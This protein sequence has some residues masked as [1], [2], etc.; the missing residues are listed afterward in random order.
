MNE[1]TKELMN[2]SYYQ[3]SSKGKFKIMI[4][5]IKLKANWEFGPDN[6]SVVIINDE[7]KDVWEISKI[8]D[9]ELILLKGTSEEKWIWATE[10]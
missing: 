5:F 8:S 3:F 4:F 1:M 6:K 10:K 9:S 2:G 7:S